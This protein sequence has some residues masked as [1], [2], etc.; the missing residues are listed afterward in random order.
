MSSISVLLNIN[1]Q[2]N[3]YTMYKEQPNLKLP[4]N[5]S[6]QC[7]TEHVY[8]YVYGTLYSL[9]PYSKS[10]YNLCSNDKVLKIL[11]GITHLCDWE[12]IY[13]VLNV[14]GNRFDI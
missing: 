8:E 2:I 3:I 11:S 12:I 13:E 6:N 10:R 9:P 1:I 7:K 4:G 14:Q 5:D